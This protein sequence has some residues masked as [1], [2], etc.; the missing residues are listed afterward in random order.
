MTEL[1]SLF[2]LPLKYLLRLF[3][4]LFLRLGGLIN[5]R[6]VL[7][8]TGLTDRDLPPLA[9]PDN[10]SEAWK[11]M[12]GP[13]MQAFFM[14]LRKYWLI[15]FVIMS[16]LIN[17]SFIGLYLIVK[18]HRFWGFH[19]ITMA[20]FI[21]YELITC[22]SGRKKTMEALGAINPEFQSD[23]ELLAS[24]RNLI[25]QYNLFREQAL[26]AMG[27][28]GKT[29]IFV[30]FFI[31]LLLMG[32]QA[33]WYL[34]PRETET[35][36]W[37]LA[38]FQYRMLEDGTAEVI[39]YTG[40]WKKI[41]VP[42][43]LHGAPVTS[44]GE[45]AFNINGDGYRPI[46]RNELEEIVLP[47]T[48]RRIGE[49]AF[50]GCRS[51]RSITLPDGVTEIGDNAFT[52]CGKL[53]VLTIPDSVTRIGTGA[54]AGCSFT[55]FHIPASVTEIGWRPFPDRL[56]ALTIAEDSPSYVLREGAL[57]SRDG[58]LIWVSRDTVG[59]EYRVPDGIRRIGALVFKNFEQL[60]RVRLPE[61]LTGVG[62]YAFSH[63]ASLEEIA[64]PDTVTSIGDFAFL[65]CSRLRGIDLPANLAYLGVSAFM[66]CESITR[67]HIPSTLKEISQGV[68][69]ECSSLSDVVISEG[70]TAIRF[71][72]FTNCFALKRVTIPS[73]VRDMDP[74]SLFDRDTVWIVTPRSFAETHAA[75]LGITCEYTEAS[76]AGPELAGDGI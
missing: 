29:I 9:P 23:T 33:D 32:L 26:R 62:E 10:A 37:Q 24:V 65:Q 7:R 70:V 60:E 28:P 6:W 57:C 16:V 64:L 22:V 38:S 19:W 21:F 39:R 71:F 12:G 56:R 18:N 43:Y 53:S 68:F 49:N 63:C 76:P 45:K 58:V 1:V 15:R 35:G 40:P 51:L 42:A 34:R 48:L 5:C 41:R 14:Y 44:I 55:T 75:R 54:F 46:R 17:A 73:S 27:R 20:S 30:S 52:S 2:L 69:F 11:I 61:G 8:K 31:A 36:V 66:G 50:S 74:Y 25:L 67:A 47:S 72:A 3:T 59:S 4:L 13:P